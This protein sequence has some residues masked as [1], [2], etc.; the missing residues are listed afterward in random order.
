MCGGTP[1]GCGAPGHGGGLS[2]RVR[3]NQSSGQGPTQENRSI[4]ACAGE[5][6]SGADTGAATT[7]YPRVCGGTRGGPRDPSPR[8]GLSPRVRGNLPGSAR[9]NEHEGSIPACA[10][11]PASGNAFHSVR[12]VYPRVCGGTPSWSLAVRPAR[13]LSPRVRGNRQ[14]EHH[15]EGG[16]RSIPACAG[17]PRWFWRISTPPEVYPRVC[18][19]TAFPSAADAGGHGLSPRVRGNP[20]RADGEV[21]AVGSIPAC[22]G[23]P[24]Q[25]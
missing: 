6:V 16:L 5:P 4:P 12:E 7:V 10:G 3:G 24:T 17:E 18:G 8:R 19:G 22:A 20:R 13:G 23:E 15:A 11:E 14:P 25:S 2:P 9:L 21:A 1:A